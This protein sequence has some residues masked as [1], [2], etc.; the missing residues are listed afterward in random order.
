MTD[1]QQ[2]DLAKAFFGT[3]DDAL[4]NRASI[5]TAAENRGV[6]VPQLLAIA[7]SQQAREFLDGP[8][9]SS[10]RQGSGHR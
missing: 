4:S 6:S 9:H 7:L 8:D 5:Q 10:D 1:Q 3:L 2:R